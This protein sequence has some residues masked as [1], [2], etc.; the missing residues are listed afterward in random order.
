MVPVRHF[1]LLIHPLQLCHL[2]AWEYDPI[3]PECLRKNIM[4]N[5]K[6]Q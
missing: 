3:S 4:C 2:Q 1:H 6:L 5:K